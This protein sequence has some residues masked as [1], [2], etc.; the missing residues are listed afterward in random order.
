MKTTLSLS[1]ASQLETEWLVAVVLD[2]NE[3]D[4]GDKAKAEAFVSTSDKAVQQAA[5]EL[6]S[7]GDITGKNFETAWLHS[8]AGVKAKRLLLIGGGKSNKFTSPEQQ[9]LGLDSR[10]TVQ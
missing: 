7:G 8:P 3:K 10:R 4:G 6:I 2:R 5:T 9:A 1:P